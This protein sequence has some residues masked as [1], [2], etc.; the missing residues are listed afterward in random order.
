[1]QP[2]LHHI[3]VQTRDL[4]NAVGWY[5]E[6]FGCRPTW[7]LAE[8]SELTTSR[9]PG[10]TRLTELVA[11]DGRFHVF[12]R[13]GV[14]GAAPGAGAMFQHVCMATSSA[15]ELQAWRRRWLGLRASG[16][17]RFARSEEATPVV[18]DGDDVQSFY[19]L[20]PDGCEFEF[21]FDPGGS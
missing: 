18:T 17:F 10:I 3:A 13:D 21:T 6:F 9:L 19:A 5:Q 14:V 16:R 20:D 11:G 15:E 1:M 8:F 2:V 12:Q 7:T 4:D